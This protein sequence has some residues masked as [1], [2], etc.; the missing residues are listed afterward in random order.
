MTLLVIAAML[1]LFVVA[2]ATLFARLASRVDAAACNTEW[3]ED[4]SL[5]SYAPMQ[6]LLDKED[7]SF[8]AGQPGYRPEISKRLLLERRKVFLEYLR[9]LVGDFNQLLVLARLMIVYSREDRQ[10]FARAL[11]RQRVNFYFAVILIWCRVTLFPLGLPARR[12]C[13]LVESVAKLRQQIQ[14]LADVQVEATHMA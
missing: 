6:R 11:W 2:F 4:F 9:N 1:L 13:D 5:D 7:F 10:E 14:Q 8:L 12:I 3:Y